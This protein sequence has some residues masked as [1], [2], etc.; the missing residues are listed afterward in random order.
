MV[1]FGSHARDDVVVRDD[2]AVGGEHD[3]ASQRGLRQRAGFRSVSGPKTVHAARIGL[4]RVHIDGGHGGRFPARRP[5]PASGRLGVGSVGCCRSFMNP[6]ASQTKRIRNRYRPQWLAR[7]RSRPNRWRRRRR[8][9][10]RRAGTC[11]RRATSSRR[12]LLLPD[13]AGAEAAD[14]TAVAADN[15]AAAP[16]GRHAGHARRSASAARGR[17]RGCCH[18]YRLGAFTLLRFVLADD[19]QAFHF[20]GDGPSP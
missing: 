4:V 9:R 5:R 16:W 8:H 3:A 20:L 1:T 14:S 15:K 17:C 7:C 6:A 12:S 11:V 13:A 18:A 10:R 2:V 19:R